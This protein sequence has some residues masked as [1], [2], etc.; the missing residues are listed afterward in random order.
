MFHNDVQLEAAFYGK[1]LDVIGQMY[2]RPEIM[3]AAY[4][5]V[6][7][8]CLYTTRILVDKKLK[9]T[10]AK[11]IQKNL[12]RGAGWEKT[13]SWSEDRDYTLPARTIEYK[14]LVSSAFS[15]SMMLGKTLHFRF[16][17]MGFTLFSNGKF[18]EQCAEASIYALLEAIYNKNENNKEALDYLYQAAVAISCLELGNHLRKGDCLKVAQEIYNDITKDYFPGLC[19]TME[20]PMD[21]S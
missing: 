13:L 17:H 20:G 18:F 15:A 2:V 12:S 4:P 3:K 8:F 21:Q 16:G 6:L 19:V 10:T 7:F 14:G 1:K 5:D 9:L 11:L